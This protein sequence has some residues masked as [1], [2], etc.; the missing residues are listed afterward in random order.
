M[1][2]MLRMRAALGALALAAALTLPVSGAASAA[3]MPD[4][5]ITTKVKMALL[6]AEDVSATQVRVDTIDGKVTLHGTVESSGE[7]ARAESAARSVTG[8]REV[9]NLLQVVDAPHK[10]A[11]A[12]ADEEIV[13]RVKTALANDK[14]LSDSSI[15]VKSVNKGLVLLSGKAATLSDHLRALEDA[16]TVPGVRR[17]TSEIQS[18]DTLAD[19]EI[20]RDAKSDP[21]LAGDS[22][23]KDAW[24]TTATK[25][26]LFANAETPASDINVDTV[27]S[28]VTLFGTVPSAAAK[29][30]AEA[31]TKKVDGVRGVVNDLQVVSAERKDAVEARDDQVKGAVESRLGTRDD[32]SDGKINVEVSNGVVR[33]SGNVASQADRLTA[34]TVAR[35]TSGVRS[36][37]SD[38]AVQQN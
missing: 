23:L 15:G 6:V 21:E 11:V 17:V 34:L 30:A 19:D 7:K 10:D 35:S 4:P 22:T 8:V 27:N 29:T 12:A 31:E 33:L 25:L 18:P 16:R 5:W 26:R 20:W 24:L 36:V 9:R 37:V 38:L 1:N 28:V 13:S 32:L 14:E 3:S 2:S